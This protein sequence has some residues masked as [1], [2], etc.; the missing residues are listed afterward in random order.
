MEAQRA[1]TGWDHQGEEGQALASGRSVSP[2]PRG[3]QRH[4]G[5]GG[6]RQP[7]EAG[8]RG[9]TRTDADTRTAPLGAAGVTCRGGQRRAAGPDSGLPVARASHFPLWP[10][11]EVGSLS[12]AAKSPL[13]APRP[14]QLRS[15]LSSSHPCGPRRG[16]TRRA[17]GCFLEVSY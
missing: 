10:E 3:R 17:S 12:P 13:D 11:A 5:A 16:S 14:L 6:D 2:E 4:G 1:R 15:H 8:W 9:Q 7:S